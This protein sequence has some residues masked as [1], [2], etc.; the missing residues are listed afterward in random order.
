MTLELI[1]NIF[2]ISAILLFGIFISIFIGKKFSI[3]KVRALVIYFWHTLFCIIGFLYL[4]KNGGDSIAYY[5]NA[6]SS[7]LLFRPGTSVI[8]LF[9]A[10]LVRIFSFSLLACFLVF[11]IFGTIGLLAF[12]GALRKVIGKNNRLLLKLATL[13]VFLPSISFW[14]SSIGKD[15]V[16][17]MATGLIL[18][19]A[20]NIKNSKN[21]ILF[22]VFCMLL[23]RPHIAALA[24]VAL[25]TS[26]IFNNSFSLKIRLLCGI[27]SFIVAMPLFPLLFLYVGFESVIGIEGVSEY[28]EKRQGY[29]MGG[30]SSID[31]SSMS[32]PMQLFTLMFRPHIFEAGTILALL[33]AI[34]NTIILLI[35]IFGS[36]AYFKKKQNEKILNYPCREDRIFM[37]IFVSLTWVVLALTTPNLGIAIRQ[38]W[39]FA[40]VL[41]YLLI[42]ILVSKK[43]I[44]RRI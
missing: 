24:L 3:N 35:F 38:K 9:T 12:D 21:L 16:F 11:N 33:A 2:S 8:I 43:H 29:N 22:A 39:M 42:S 28:I 31:I 30:G 37:W 27:S 20:T 15:S 41:I 32:F 10:L 4:I 6:K 5:D 36:V 19:A 25:M 44:R 23:I 14:T 7:I 17:F 18:W 34:D 1:W 13:I 26:F 40:P